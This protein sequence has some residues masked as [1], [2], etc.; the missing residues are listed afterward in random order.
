MIYILEDMRLKGVKVRIKGWQNPEGYEKGT[1]ACV[2][3][4]RAE[5]VFCLQ[6]TQHSW[7]GSDN[8]DEH[9]SPEGTCG[10]LMDYSGAYEFLR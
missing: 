5:K 6:V 9:V 1:G 3:N 10:G 4:F 8:E 2:R 7:N